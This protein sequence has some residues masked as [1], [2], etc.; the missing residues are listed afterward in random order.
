[1]RE[2]KGKEIR[3]MLDVELKAKYREL[4][5]EHFNLRYQLAIGQCSNPARFKQVRRDLAKVLT[6]AKERGLTLR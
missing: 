2:L 3:G 6:V 1:L 4:K 5:E